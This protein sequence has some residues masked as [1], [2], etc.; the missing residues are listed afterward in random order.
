MF[1]FNTWKKNLTTLLKFLF[2]RIITYQKYKKV[3]NLKAV[4]QKLIDSSS[5]SWT[6]FPISK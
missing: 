3:P 5:E 4:V 2:K 1:I 6:A